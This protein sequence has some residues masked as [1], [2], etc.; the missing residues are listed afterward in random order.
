M[1]RI[2][3]RR[4]GVPPRFSNKEEIS[5]RDAGAAESFGQDLQDGQDWAFGGGVAGNQRNSGRFG[6]AVMGMESVGSALSV[7]YVPGNETT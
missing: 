4:C 3:V 1:D 7:P 2:W 6:E 5:R